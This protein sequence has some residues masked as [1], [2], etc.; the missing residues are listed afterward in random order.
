MKRSRITWFYAHREERNKHIIARFH[1]TH[2][3]PNF[4][5]KK[6]TPIERSSNIVF[7]SSKNVWIFLY[8]NIPIGWAVTTDVCFCTCWLD[9]ICSP[10]W[11]PFRIFK[12]LRWWPASLCHTVQYLQTKRRQNMYYYALNSITDNRCYI[13]KTVHF[14]F[15]IS[16]KSLLK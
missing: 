10:P 15:L 2:F 11:N 4:P 16:I 3:H 12:I 6:G 13:Y 9:G 1:L 7:F 14:Q 5:F 8:S